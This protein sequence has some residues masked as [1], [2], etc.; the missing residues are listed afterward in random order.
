MKHRNTALSAILGLGIAAALGTVSPVQA[1]TS[2]QA[3][4]P[5]TA[6]LGAQHYASAK[7]EAGNKAFFDAVMKS[8][9][10]KQAAH[11]GL[12]SVTITYDARPRPVTRA[13]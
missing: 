8:V 10:K 12:K 7:Q 1:A 9:A 11:P 6:Q 5:H 13:R 3:P 2:T 4:V